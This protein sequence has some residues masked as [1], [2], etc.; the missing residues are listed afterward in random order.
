MTLIVK[1]NWLNLL[2]VILIVLKVLNE[3]SISWIWV[4]APFWIPGSIAGIIAVVRFIKKRTL[5]LRAAMPLFFL[6]WIQRRVFFPNAPK[7]HYTI[8]PTICQAKFG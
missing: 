3:I 2:G 7:F 5:L 1:I 8:A 6:L 4:F